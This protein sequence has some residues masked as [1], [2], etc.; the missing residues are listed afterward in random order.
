MLVPYYVVLVYGLTSIICMYLSTLCSCLEFHLPVC[1]VNAFV[2]LA[3]AYNQPIWYLHLPPTSHPISQKAVLGDY[4]LVYSVIE[5]VFYYQ[6]PLRIV[7][8]V[9]FIL[10]DLRTGVFM[11]LRVC[12]A[13][14]FT[15][16]TEC[17]S[18]I[19]QCSYDISIVGQF[20][21]VFPNV[22]T[23]RQRVT[24][25]RWCCMILCWTITLWRRNS[26]N[27]M[28]NIIFIVNQ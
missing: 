10:N 16:F 21:H 8:K 27:V 19:F 6:K 14:V 28:S 17:S 24:Q 23:G 9:I 1:D 25:W 4:T 3:G 12:W 15:T 20:G 13:L 7:W 2:L 22:R 5:I 11:N 26:D 18:A